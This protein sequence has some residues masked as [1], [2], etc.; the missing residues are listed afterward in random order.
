MDEAGM[1][2]SLSMCSVLKIVHQAK[3]KLV[4]VGDPAQLQ[5]VGPG[6]SFRALVERL[7]FAEMQT[8]YRQSIPWQRQATVDFSSGAMAKGLAA[9]KAENCIHVEVTPEAAMQKLLKEWQRVCG[10][11]SNLN[12]VLVIAHRN[13]DIQ[14]LNA[15]LRN[16]RVKEGKIDSGYTVKTSKG[17]INIAS[18][19][20]I[21][22]LKNDRQLGVSN[23]RFA[24]VE[25]VEFTESKKVLSFTVKLDGSDQNIT[26]NPY[27]Y[28]DFTHGYAATVHKTQGMTV[29]HSLVYIGSKG[30]NRHLTYVALSRHRQSCQVYADRQTHAHDGILMRRLSRLGLKDSVLDFPLAFAERR[31]I[32]HQS[33]SQKLSAHLTER[34]TTWKKQISDKIGQWISADKA[35]ERETENSNEQLIDIDEKS[36]KTLLMRYVDMELEQTRLVNA[37]HTARLQ[38]QKAA[39]EL[40]MQILTH[41][42]SI[43]LFAEQAIQ[44]PDI[45]AT[46]EAL[47]KTK[48]ISLVQCGGFTAIRERLHKNELSQED[49]CV[50]AVK[51]RSKA[52]SESHMQV[53]D[54]SRGGR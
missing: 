30:W 54:R 21:L 41:S 5:P 19:D 14:A 25:S 49:L 34:L 10:E 38:D 18:G 2:D 37:M 31:G 20:R 24:T 15:L 22:F 3:A 4:L 29:D 42:K 23:G 36:F 45:K 28:S 50:L 7:G 11:A 26:I 8:V 44:H 32:D 52:L 12:Q 9:Y 16:E 13:E 43:Q 53:R 39:K 40:S 1:T 27:A 46:I 6:A 17:E 47:Q 48:P 51:L 35:L 33:M